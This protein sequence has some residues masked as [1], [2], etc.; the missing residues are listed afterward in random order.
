MNFKFKV[1]KAE[2]VPIE[3]ERLGAINEDKSNGN[4]ERDAKG[5]QN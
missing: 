1:N 2:H 4:V 5:G 3:T